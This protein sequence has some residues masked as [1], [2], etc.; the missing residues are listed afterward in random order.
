MQDAS[1]PARAA[2]NDGAAIAD[3]SAIT[4]G[5]SA[6]APSVTLIAK[7]AKERFTMTGFNSE[8]TI[9]SVKELICEKTNI[10]PKRQKLV[11][12]TKKAG[13]AVGDE[14]V[15]GDLKIKKS[16]GK[17]NGLPAAEAN[18]IVHEFILVRPM[19]VLQLRYC[20]EIKLDVCLRSY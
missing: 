20:V 4:D 6:T 13:G 3:K 1:T 11:G 16:K 2:D 10:L 7:W 5:I 18:A 8:T 17:T 14:V 9:A 19:L 12:L 15:L